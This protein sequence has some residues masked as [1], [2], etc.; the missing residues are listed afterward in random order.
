VAAEPTAQHRPVNFQGPI[1]SPGDS[2]TS[3]T[4]SREEMISEVTQA[5]VAVLS[6]RKDFKEPQ[7]PVVHD[8]PVDR[9]HASTDIPPNTFT[10]DKSHLSEVQ[11]YDNEL[12]HNA[13]NSLK[14][15][16]EMASA[17]I[18]GFWSI[19]I[20]VT[21]QMTIRGIS[22]CRAAMLCCRLSINPR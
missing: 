9:E 17:L 14:L 19:A 5:V 4:L 18:L 1:S 16:I 12:G 10:N 20:L 11:S 22:P 2:G 13:S 6:Q 15:K 8:E 21:I 7:P 3:T